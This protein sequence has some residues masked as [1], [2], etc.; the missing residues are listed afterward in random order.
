[1]NRVLGASCMAAKHGTQ[2]Q[3]ANRV[4]DDGYEVQIVCGTAIVGRELHVRHR[5][6]GANRMRD[7]TARRELLVLRSYEAQTTYAVR[8]WD[9]SLVRDTLHARCPGRR[10]CTPWAR[11]PPATSARTLFNR[12]TC[13][14][15][16]GGV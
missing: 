10:G 1:M 3:G 2:L 12:S 8:L 9:A 14:P 15:D 4:W 11:T 7:S 13:L 5:L 16:S 6:P